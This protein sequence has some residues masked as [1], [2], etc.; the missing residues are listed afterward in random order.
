MLLSNPVV[1][2]QYLLPASP[3][4]YFH[5]LHTICR[6]ANERL[7]IYNPWICKK[8]RG[9]AKVTSCNQF[10]QT[11]LYPSFCWKSFVANVRWQQ[12]IPAQLTDI[13]AENL[14]SPV[15][16]LAQTAQARNVA[17]QT[18][19]QRTQLEAQK[20]LIMETFLIYLVRQLVIR[21]NGKTMCKRN[22]YWY[23][24]TL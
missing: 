1:E 20:I 24:M 15:S 22:Q 7:W 6:F 10:K 19:Q 4:A 13:L 23:N 11:L 16:L 18:L 17:A 21:L 12:R 5:A 2:S 8:G 3:A 14:G 9:S